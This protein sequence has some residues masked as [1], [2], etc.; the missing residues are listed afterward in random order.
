MD[1]GYDLKERKV[2]WINDDRMYLNDKDFKMLDRETYESSPY[3]S[4]YKYSHDVFPAKAG[5]G[6]NGCTD[7][8]SFSSDIFYGKVVKYPF[9][10]DA[11]PVFEQQYK[12]LGMSS[13]IVWLSAFREQFIKTFEYPAIFFLFLTVMFSVAC[14][15]NKKQ[16]Y[17]PVKPKHLLIGYGLLVAGF[18]LVYLKPD[19]KA[20]ILPDRLL[21]DK[22]HFIITILVLIAGLFTW[23]QMKKDEKSNSI[24]SRLQ[25]VFL[26]ISVLSGLFMMIKFESIYQVA[27]VAYTLFDLSII[28]SVLTSIIYLVNDQYRSLKTEVQ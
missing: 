24:L 5:L 23:L 25:L 2:V 9:G 8:H 20:Y 7:C 22:N 11:N 18:A 13:F 10:D 21:L 26:S 14:Y 12:K 15:I 28:L 4:V 1:A 27:R 3:A 17:F 19:V 6:I 16:N